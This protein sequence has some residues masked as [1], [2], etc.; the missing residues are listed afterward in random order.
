MVDLVRFRILATD[1]QTEESA[2]EQSK[3][4]SPDLVVN[5]GQQLLIDNHHAVQRIY[6]DGH[7]A[8]RLSLLKWEKRATQGVRY[9]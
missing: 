8:D 7:K 5:V 6:T 1:M 9:S 2:W 4:Q 3:Q